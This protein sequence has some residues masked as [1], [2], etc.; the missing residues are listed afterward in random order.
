MEFELTRYMS[1]Y[2]YTKEYI[3]F[4]FE[5][6]LIDS[7]NFAFSLK[8]IKCYE[9]MDVKKQQNTSIRIKMKYFKRLKNT[10]FLRKESNFYF[11]YPPF[12]MTSF[13][14]GKTL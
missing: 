9:D 4:K 3:H 6:I 13:N 12:I 7:F 10:F 1:R 2:R 5:L 14:P 11:Q 8:F